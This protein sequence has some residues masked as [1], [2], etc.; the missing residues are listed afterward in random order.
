M[1][2]NFLIRW[3][4][5]D[6]NSKILTRNNSYIRN[7]SFYFCYFHIISLDPLTYHHTSILTCWL[8]LFVSTFSI[9]QN[10]QST[11]LLN[12]LSSGEMLE[13]Y[14]EEMGTCL[15]HLFGK[16]LQRASCF[17]RFSWKIIFVIKVEIK[18]G[19]W[20][21][22][23]CKENDKKLCFTSKKKT[24]SRLYWSKIKCIILIDGKRS[25]LI[26]RK[27]EN[28]ISKFRGKAL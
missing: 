23:T 17:T 9:F 11:D 4:K 13:C 16:L 20:M 12:I 24:F 26:T 5:V 15:E 2:K 6:S 3:F 14:G 27:K 28:C 25:K 8:I 21:W 1:S 7:V 19:T 10:V 22:R 18:G